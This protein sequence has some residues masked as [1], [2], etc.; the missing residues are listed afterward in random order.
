MASTTAAP[1]SPTS[2]PTSHPVSH[3]PG[4]RRVRHEVRDSLAV[5]AFSA[6]SSLTVAVVL[7]LLVRFGS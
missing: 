4:T 1:H 3:D 7:T 2:R 5:M 6:V